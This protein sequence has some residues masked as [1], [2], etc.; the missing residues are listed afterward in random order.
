MTLSTDAAINRLTRRL[1]S[2]WRRT[3][4]RVWRAL[5]S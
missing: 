2:P 3:L 1:R 4:T 5:T